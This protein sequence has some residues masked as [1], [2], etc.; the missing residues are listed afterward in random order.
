M[1]RSAMTQLQALP[2]ASAAIDPAN[3]YRRTLGTRL[4]GPAVLALGLPVMGLQLAS[5][6]LFSGFTLF[7]LGALLAAAF[8]TAVT[9][10][11]LFELSGTALVYHNPLARLAGRPARIEFPYAESRGA[12]VGRRLNRV[13]KVECGKRRL[14]IEGIEAFEEFTRRFQ[15]AAARGE[16]A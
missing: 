15:E 12:V 8:Y 14:L 6:A 7:W 13:F 16:G 5:G 2:T 10:T 9:W 1:S 4:I 11:D 3:R